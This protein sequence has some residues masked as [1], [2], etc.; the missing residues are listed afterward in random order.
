MAKSRTSSLCT[1]KFSDGLFRLIGSIYEDELHQLNIKGFIQYW[2]AENIRIKF[3]Y[4]K[5]KI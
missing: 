4:L 1:T 5:F 2:E 3:N